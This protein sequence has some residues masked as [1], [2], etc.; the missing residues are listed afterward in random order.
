MKTEFKDCTINDGVLNHAVIGNNNTVYT[1]IQNDLQNDRF[2]ECLEEVIKISNNKEEQ[3]CAK[4]AKELYVSDKK[5]F[6]NFLIDNLASFTTGTFATVSGG[7]LLS[8]IKN[9]LR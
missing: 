8:Y 5:S 7:L 4:K 3:R 9:F 6:K 2:I 1:V